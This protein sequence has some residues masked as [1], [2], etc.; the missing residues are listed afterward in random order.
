MD[1]AI[2]VLLCIM[3]A[4]FGALFVIAHL[5]PDGRPYVERLWEKQEHDD[6]EHSVGNPL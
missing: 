2:T 6:T 4:I 3:S 1:T 5:R